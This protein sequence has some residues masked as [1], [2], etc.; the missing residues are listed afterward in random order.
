[1]RTPHS[2]ELRGAARRRCCRGRA[3]LAGA[4]GGRARLDGAPATLAA[5]EQLGP[6]GRGSRAMGGAEFQ[7]AVVRMWWEQLDE[8][9]DRSSG[10]PRSARRRREL[11]PASACCW[12]RPSA[13]AAGST[14]GGARERGSR[15]R[16]AGRLADARRL[17]ACAP[18]TRG[19]APRRRRGRALGDGAGARWPAVRAAGRRA[20]R[21]G[22][23][24][25]ARASL[26]RC[27]EAVGVLQSLVAF[28]RRRTCV[29]RA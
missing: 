26:G 14:S 23:A 3:G 6:S 7:V 27:A 5:A 2:Q 8:A 10:M 18:R 17:R 12:R 11:R 4:R 28:A 1:M 13:C 9:E 29:S 24:R 19:R 20:L 15:A 22:G 16:G 21:D 25:A